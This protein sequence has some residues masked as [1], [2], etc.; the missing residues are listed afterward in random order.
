MAMRSTVSFLARRE[1]LGWLWRSDSWHLSPGLRVTRTRRSD[2]S[3]KSPAKLGVVHEPID[4]NRLHPLTIA[5]KQGVQNMRRL[6]C[7]QLSLFF[8][9][10]AAARGAQ[11]PIPAAEPTAPPRVATE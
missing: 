11:P 10:A 7:I 5:R 2:T 9:A 6:T 1:P 3:Q 4:L 8:L